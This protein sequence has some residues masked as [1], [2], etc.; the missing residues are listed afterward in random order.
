MAKAPKP[1][2]ETLPTGERVLREAPDSL[3]PDG[4]LTLLQ[5]SSPLREHFDRAEE[6]HR[7]ALEELRAQEKAAQDAYKARLHAAGLPPEKHPL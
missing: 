4:K 5:D 1:K 7:A 3:H 2:I 6:G